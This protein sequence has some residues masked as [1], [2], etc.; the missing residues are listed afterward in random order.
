MKIIRKSKLKKIIKY[1]LEDIQNES[2]L[3]NHHLGLGDHIICNGLAN[4]LSE[5]SKF[6][7]MPVKKKYYEMVKFLFSENPKIQ[8][9]AL[10]PNID[11]VDQ[12]NFFAYKNDLEILRVGYEKTSTPF[13]EGFYSQLGLDYSVSKTKF[14]L[15]FDSE[16]SLKLENHLKKI[17]NIYNDY[18]IFHLES[19]TGKYKLENL[20]IESNHDAVFIEKDTDLF[21]NL[22][23]YKNLI[24]NAKSIHC[25]DSAVFHLVE[26]L[27]T[28]GDLYFHNFKNNLESLNF[29][30][31][32][33]I[34]NY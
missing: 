6:I 26:R 4:Y 3:L 27:E 19:T 22:F 23:L 25:I 21:N 30:K 32:W 18:D 28:S 8:L 2:F 29:F 15:P 7:F 1:S 12:I 17:Y 5:S 11:E 9:F 14:K 31:E 13:S 33:K 20:K 34:I 16:K 24:I 10:N